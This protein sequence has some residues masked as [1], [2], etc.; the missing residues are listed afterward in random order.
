MG[1]EIECN[2]DEQFEDENS[3]PMQD[4]RPRV[5]INPLI[6]EALITEMNDKNWKVGAH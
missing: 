4:V 3:T 1:D 6:T 5:D 2:G